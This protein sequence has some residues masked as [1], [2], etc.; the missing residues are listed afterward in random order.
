MQ[1][2]KVKKPRRKV[3]RWWKVKVPS[4]VPKRRK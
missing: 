4:I 3:N 2:I 1:K